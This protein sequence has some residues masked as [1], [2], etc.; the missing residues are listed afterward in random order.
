M[1]QGFSKHNS[2]F[3]VEWSQKTRHHHLHSLYGH[4]AHGYM[5]PQKEEE[6]KLTILDLFSS[7]LYKLHRLIFFNNTQKKRPYKANT[8]EQKIYRFLDN[9]LFKFFKK[10]SSDNVPKPNWLVLL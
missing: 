9:Y 3:F 7:L 2:N 5:G 6:K 10:G 4:K 1:Y 8:T